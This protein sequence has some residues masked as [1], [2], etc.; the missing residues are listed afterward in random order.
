[1]SSP[2]LAITTSSSTPTTSSIPRASFAPPVP[3][4]S[5][6]TGLLTA[7]SQAGDLDA[8]PDLVP[9]VDRDDQGRQLLDDSRHLKRPAIHRPQALDRLDQLGQPLLVIRGIAAHQD[10][11][12]K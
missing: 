7:S 6:T 5:T 11:L 10:V 3:P 2:V 8:R 1:M 9:D 12:I 4:A